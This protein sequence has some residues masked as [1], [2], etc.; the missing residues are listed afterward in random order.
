MSD[1]IKK[2]DEWNALQKK[3]NSKTPIVHFKKRQIWWAS[4]GVNVG[5]EMDGKNGNFERPVLVI[6]K[7]SATSAFVVPLTSTIREEDERLVSYQIKDKKYSASIS[8]A[9]PI[10][11]RRFI[12][13]I[14]SKMSNKD[15]VKI[16]TC[17]KNQF[18]K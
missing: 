14:N 2:F 9:R 8:Q 13:R 1:Y 16:I 7:I 18:S 4:I 10:D 12:R 3:V 15:F 5:T 11:T 17:F 6:K